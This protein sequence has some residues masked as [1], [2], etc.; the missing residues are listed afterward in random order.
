MRLLNFRP[1]PA[2]KAGGHAAGLALSRTQALPFVHTPSTPS[3]A[4]PP[5][6]LPLHFLKRMTTTGL[7][8]SAHSPYWGLSEAH[9]YSS[10]P[11]TPP[12][13]PTLLTPRFQTSYIACLHVA[14]R[15]YPLTKQKPCRVSSFTCCPGAP[16]TESRS[17]SLS[18]SGPTICGVPVPNPWDMSHET[19]SLGSPSHLISTRWS[20]SG[21]KTVFPSGKPPR[22]KSPPRTRQSLPTKHVIRLPPVYGACTALTVASGCHQDKSTGGGSLRLKI[23]SYIY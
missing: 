15:S 3:S 14:S 22:P 19:L 7:S 12:M 20:S 1:I 10:S 18:G 13:T 17:D 4:S 2:I 6:P 5:Q 21:S 16:N 11:G 23:S 8:A 9:C